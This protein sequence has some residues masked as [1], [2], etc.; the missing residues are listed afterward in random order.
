MNER[1]AAS[2]STAL[3]LNKKTGKPLWI[4]RL[5]IYY[6]AGAASSSS[7]SSVVRG[8]LIATICSI[9]SVMIS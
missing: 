4:F 8:S 9:A 5:I 6:S 1:V 3:F 7:A 2:N